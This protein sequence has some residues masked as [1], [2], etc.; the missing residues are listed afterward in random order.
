MIASHEPPTLVAGHPR[1]GTP[2]V[3]ARTPV[4]QLLLTRDRLRGEDVELWAL[5]RSA[6]SPEA[7]AAFRDVFLDL[8]QVE[9]P[10]LAQVLDLGGTDETFFYSR[11]L[12]A[13]ESM[14]HGPAG[15][16]QFGAGGVDLGDEHAL[17]Q[18]LSSFASVL[19]ELHVAGLVHGFIIP[20]HLQVDVRKGQLA[21]VWLVEAGT[22][23]L[24]PAKSAA[25]YRRYL[26]PEVR[27]GGKPTPASDLYSLGVVLLEAVEGALAAP[28]RR[29]GAASAPDAVVIAPELRELLARLVATDP[30]GR[31]ADGRALAAWLREPSWVLPERRPAIEHLL[32]PLLVGRG[33]AISA[34]DSLLTA[35]AA[36]R[37]HAG[38]IVG[39]AGSGRSRLL[40]VV[41]RKAA[42]SGWTTVRVGG[43]AKGRE[44]DDLMR[45][46]GSELGFGE[47]ALAPDPSAPVPA[48]AQISVAILRGLEQGGQRLLVL[49]DDAADLSPDVI[50]ALKHLATE[51][52][53]I[54]VLV[55]TTGLM[56]SELPDAEVIEIHR[57]GE[58]DLRR[59]LAPLLAEALDPEP[60]F[61]AIQSAADGNPFRVRVLLCTWLDSRRLTCERGRIRYDERAGAPVPTTIEAEVRDL[62]DH[63]E[64]RA[65]ELVEVMA[66]WG[67]PLPR[68][69]AARIIGGPFT[70]PHAVVS[71]ASDQDL[72]FLADA[73]GPLLL[74]VL[75][76][77]RRRSWHE[78]ILAAL[79]GMSVEPGVRAPHL[80]AT[81][82]VAAA[83]GDLVAAAERAEAAGALHTALAHYRLALDRAA[84]LA[85]HAVDRAAIAL[86][87]AR[88]ATRI[89]DLT[90]S[91]AVLAAIAPPE[92]DP[93][94]PPRLR[95]ET[96]L[97]RAHMFRERRL[98]QEAAGAYGAARALACAHPELTPELVQ[99]DL[100]EAGNDLCTSHWRDG[101]MRLAPHLAALEAAGG[102][103]VV[104]A[105]ALNRMATLQI[106]GGKGR[107]AALCAVRAA[108]IARRASDLP[109]AARALINLGHIHEQLGLPRRALRALDRARSILARCPHEGLRASELTNRGQVL[110]A[111]GELAPA[112]TALLQARA[113]RLRT[114]DHGR[115]P[116]ILIGLG[117][118]LRHSGRLGAAGT[119]YEQA[120][121]IAE[122]FAL[123]AAHTARGHLGELLLWQGEW[124]EAERLLRAALAES[125][126][127]M[128][129][130]CRRNLATLLRWQGRYAAA[131]SALDECRQ[132]LRGAAARE[133]LAIV[134]MARVHLDAGD[135][136]AAEFCVAEA[137][138]AAESTD[139][140]LRAEYHLA[141]GM[142][143][144]RSGL[145]PRPALDQALAAARETADATFLAQALVDAIH[146]LL[147]HEKHRGDPACAPISLSSR[148][149]PRGPT[150]ATW[151]PSCARCAEISHRAFHLR[152]PGR[153]LPRRSSAT[154][155]SRGR[156]RRRHCS[157]SSCCG[158]AAPV[159]RSCSRSGSRRRAG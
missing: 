134:E 33:Q 3:L 75:T 106:V 117:R 50:A 6:V 81:G 47:D 60:L 51:A 150:R 135:P 122:E 45:V 146:A 53:S 19:G 108:R 93:S 62:L 99:I 139:A 126:P 40:G 65:R 83:V 73:F 78:A 9:H 37:A 24:M 154:W 144:A 85:P 38:D 140:A 59:M 21:G 116:A 63:L 27:T 82:Q 25:P 58:R 149:Q 39:E 143:E 115:L 109:L 2:A 42:A 20:E 151:P 121:A 129:G 152:V 87:A 131:L 14:R 77:D 30:N 23:L 133:A 103:P 124:R 32:S 76:E 156:A 64:P 159:A 35:A 110:L 66:V 91:R 137:S 68:D 5:P 89:G 44:L 145:D 147:S 54:P 153:T 97:L 98:T 41:A 86:A 67:R 55:L 72:R 100:E 48:Y 118:L 11:E 43:G 46:V 36:G 28:R 52:G 119:Y 31:P 26:A 101:L 125:R 136:A 7:L 57:L 107:E 148:R 111:L 90:E 142:L 17:F 56:P 34:T 22:H 95:L 12:T 120:L 112:E 69:L 141:R 13:L 8:R 84:G 96:L 123:P 94:A 4:G 155:W 71:G 102:P 128:R 104:L 29:R 18:C 74:H 114:G 1:Y 113:I 127:R 130:L 15:L 61:R 49:A 16:G 79:A 105:A 132:E 70:V 10:H 157:A 158:S 138:A 88:L 92:D 80:L